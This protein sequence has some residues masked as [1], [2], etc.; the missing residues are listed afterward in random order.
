MRRVVLVVVIALAVLVPGLSVG[1]PR[2][3]AAIEPGC[4]MSID[5]P[6]QSNGANRV[7]AYASCA[8]D[9]GVREMQVCIYS[10]GYQQRCTWVR[11][12]STATSISARAYCDQ[13]PGGATVATQGWVWFY[14][15]NGQVATAWSVVKYLPVC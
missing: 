15:E 3:S 11:S 1:V 5:P 13:S 7:Y 12:P 6:Y 8:N 4:W 10:N 2:V 9:P 14:G